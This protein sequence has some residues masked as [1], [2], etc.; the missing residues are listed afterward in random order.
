MDRCGDHEQELTGKTDAPV[1]V[2]TP[3]LQETLRLKMDDGDTRVRVKRR[4]RAV[5][6]LHEHHPIAEIARTLGVQR[7]S[8]R[9]W[10]EA[11]ARDGLQSLQDA[12][13]VGRPPLRKEGEIVRRTLL[14]RP[15]GG[16]L[17]STRRLAEA[18]GVSQTTVVKVWEAAGLGP[19]YTRLFPADRWPR[20]L[21]RRWHVKA[22]VIVP[23]CALLA[24]DFGTDG[25]LTEGGGFLRAFPDSVY[26][27][28]V[29]SEPT[30]GRWQRRLA[31]VYS[32]A[33]PSDVEAALAICREAVAKTSSAGTRRWVVGM[34]VLTDYASLRRQVH[35]RVAILPNMSY[36]S[37]LTG[38]V[39]DGQ[40]RGG[41]DGLVDAAV[42]F[43]RSPRRYFSWP[44]SLQ[45]ALPQP[46]E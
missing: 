22:L 27:L 25:H 43:V 29:P 42:A 12:P 13:R 18:V 24:V 14:F 1:I 21:P 2:L 36:W 31:R 23:P 39:L 6:L 30:H 5:L 8:V 41:L 20:F 26:G 37:H 10:G 16:G 9:T 33:R 38:L 34:H 46:Q 7:R 15:Q 11:F 28:P 44:R 4:A 40:K 3:S 17:W 19:G 45:D 35:P 32:A